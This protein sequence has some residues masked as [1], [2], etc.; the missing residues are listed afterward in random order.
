MRKPGDHEED[1]D[2][3]EP[4]VKGP[5]RRVVERHQQHGEGAETLDVLPEAAMHPDRVRTGD[6][7]AAHPF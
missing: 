5:I 7:G 4:A 2:P 3:D 6:Q 1:V